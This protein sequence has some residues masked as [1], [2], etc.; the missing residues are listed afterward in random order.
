MSFSSEIKE[1][2]NCIQTLSNK[3]LVKSE[4]QGYLISN[5]AKI[6]KTGTKLKIKFSTESEYNI[7]RFARLLGNCKI[8]EYKIQIQ[9]KKYV[10]ELVKEKLYDIVNFTENG[11]EIKKQ[12]NVNIENMKAI[13]RGTFLGA[14][15][16]NNPENSNH[17]EVQLSNKNNCIIVEE[18]LKKFGIKTKVIL[19]KTI[20]IKDGEEIS[21]FL[22][23]IGANKSVLKFEDIRVKHEMSNKINRLVNCEGANLNKIM[24]ASI[25]Q[26]EAINRLKRDNKFESLEENLKE[27][28][29]LRLQNPNAN[30]AELGKMLK[31]PIGKSGVNY[32]L[33]KIIELS[34]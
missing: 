26:I 12:E 29:K 25:E 9:G 10:I 19:E 8:Q 14:G 5:N 2:L 34:K 21:K 28:A 27:I 16:I 30:L 6:I 4:L 1:E 11:I 31:N 32:R 23:C 3:E 18:M 24:N 33:K 20:Y 22:A 15:S 7:N 17:L 13:I